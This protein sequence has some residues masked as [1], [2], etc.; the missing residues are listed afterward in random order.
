M[1]YFFL[2]LEKNRSFDFV[3]SEMQ[4][5]FKFNLLEKITPK[6]L[7][8]LLNKVNTENIRHFYRVEDGIIRERI[9]E[10]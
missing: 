4:K 6:K 9:T 7:R 3:Q 1:E 10:A 2:C 5:R 8:L